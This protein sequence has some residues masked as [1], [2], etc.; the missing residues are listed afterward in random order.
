MNTSSVRRLLQSLL[1]VAATVL[2]LVLVPISPASA[3]PGEGEFIDRLNALR[4][5]RALPPLAWAGDLTVVA[6]GHSARMAATNTLYHNPNLTTQVTNWLSVGENVGYGGSVLAVHNAL[7]ASAPHLANM[8]NTSYTQ[9]GV[10]TATSGDG[11]LW[12]TQVFRRPLVAVAAF[13][14]YGAIGATYP[15]VAHVLGAPTSAEY[16]VPGGRGQAFQNGEMLWSWSSGAREVHGGILGRYRLLGATRSA[17]GFPVTHEMATPD[18]RGRFNHFQGGSVYW[19]PST[20]AFEIRGGIRAAWSR[21]GWERSSLGYPVTDELGTPD[22]AGR[23]NHFQTGSIYWTPWT[24]AREVRG[25][26]RNHWAAMGWERGLGY[27]VSDEYAVPGGRRSD[28]QR[29][30]IFWDARTGMTRLV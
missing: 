5:S 16:D 20:G 19:S 21:L 8:L 1:A 25:G 6:Q 12:V 18:G 7:V 10:G 2:A 9:V 30:S 23:F 29:G 26:I 4:V 24:G 13:P 27:P 17:L 11:R 14:L 3:G 15:G 28:F 22:G